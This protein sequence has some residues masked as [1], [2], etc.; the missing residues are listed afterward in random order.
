MISFEILGVIALMLLAVRELMV[1]YIWIMICDNWFWNRLDPEWATVVGCI[2]AVV[3]L[4]WGG[5]YL[6][7]HIDVRLS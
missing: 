5:E 2:S 6:H 4:I 1:A 7:S 3:V